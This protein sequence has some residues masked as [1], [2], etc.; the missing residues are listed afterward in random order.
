MGNPLGKG[1]ESLIPN[2]E[3][4]PPEAAPL[5]ILS[6]QGNLIEPVYRF[7]DIEREIAE[8][9]Q[10]L[11]DP[12][13]IVVASSPSKIAASGAGASEPRRG[14]SI[15][16][17]DVGKIEPNPQQPRHEFNMDE[18]LTLASSVKE[19]GVLQPLLVT[20]RE[21]DTASGMGVKYE[22]IAGERRWRA[23]KLAGLREVPV[24]IRS[25]EMPEKNKLEIALIENV[26]REDLNPMERARAFGRLADEF[27][28]TQKDIALRIGKSRE[29]VANALR[30]LR[31]PED[32]QL[33][34]ASNLITEG[35]ARILLTLESDLESQRELFLKITTGNLTVRGA[36]FTARTL[37]GSSRA[38]V[39]R[40]RGG[41]ALDPDARALLRALE[42]VFGTRVLLEKKGEHGK[43]IVE[44]FSDEELEGI[45]RRI[46]KREEGYI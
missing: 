39:R 18:L 19:H 12:N 6:N 34:I 30:L 4:S 28:L 40:K 17:I 3:S 41:E 23:A 24:I 43:I 26:Q 11:N 2:K 27:G 22:L 37:A 5:D 42:E 20:K 9:E 14:D 45:L 44:F 33:A 25:A 31:L 10:K 35:H 13:V 32:I 29:T 36:D 7:Y 8:K 15:F 16:W 46:A 21:F 1:L 38:R